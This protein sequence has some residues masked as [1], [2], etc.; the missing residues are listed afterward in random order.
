MIAAQSIKCGQN[1]IVI[2]GGMENMSNV[3]HYFSKGRKGQKLG[4]MTLIDGLVKDGLTDVYN[5]IHMGL[6]AEKC[7][8]EMNFT[9]QDQDEFAKESYKR[10]TS[11]WIEGKF[12]DEIVTV[13]VPQRRGNSIFINEDEEYKNIKID[14]ISKLRPVFDKNGTITAAN[15]STLNDG[16]SALILMSEEK[17]KELKLKV[18]A[19]IKGF[20]D[21][22]QEPEWFTTSPAKAV[23]IAIKNAGL[24]LSLIHI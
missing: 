2:A 16:A 23:P 13:E 3:P 5:K 7:A 12:K 22:S 15:A 17:A 24:S 6:C 18:I 11:A 14:K 1:H 19:K 9:R 20:A 8:S 4:D 21:A 10:S